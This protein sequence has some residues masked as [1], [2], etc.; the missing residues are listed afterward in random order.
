MITSFYFGYKR[1]YDIFPLD[2]FRD[3]GNVVCKTIKK[4]IAKI[5]KKR[6]N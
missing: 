5:F 1:R 6:H 3:L 4:S 2:F